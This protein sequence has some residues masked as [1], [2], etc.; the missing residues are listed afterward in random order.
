MTSDVTAKLQLTTQKN[1]LVLQPAV[2]DAALVDVL[3]TLDTALA[4][5]YLKTDTLAFASNGFKTLFPASADTQR[6][7]AVLEFE[8]KL[9]LAYELAQS[10]INEGLAESEVELVDQRYKITFKHVDANQLLLLSLRP[11]EMGK[12]NLRDYMQAR[13]SLF[14]TSRTI[15]VSEM[16]TTLAHEINTPIGTISN[17]LR[18]VKMRL[19]KPNA[20]ADVLDEALSRALEQTQFT[21]NVV[22]RIRDFTQTRRPKHRVLNL[23]EQITDAVSLLDWMLSKNNCL[24]SATTPD[25]PVLIAG[26]AT[27]LQQ[28]LINL[29]RNAVDAMERQSKD[30]RYITIGVSVAE[31]VVTVS[32]SDT[33]AGLESGAKNLFVPFVTNKANGMGVGLIICRSFVELHQGRLWLSPNDDR[34]CTSYME[35]PLANQTDIDEQT[36]QSSQRQTMNTAKSAMPDLAQPTRSEQG[37]TV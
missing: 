28:V 21:Q 30:Q 7:S 5:V 24:L 19:R 27:M 4:I 10:D 26:D 14:S 37:G 20:S 34:G 25:E 2:A 13:D 11:L 6:W 8:A 17:I 33:G 32:I 16:A 23:C 36:M 18:G 1:G 35:L 22:N 15:S 3:A 9:C 31:S 29:L 12:E